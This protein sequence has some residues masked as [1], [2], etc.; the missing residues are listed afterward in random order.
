MEYGDIALDKPVINK[1][2]MAILLTT[3]ERIIL[4]RQ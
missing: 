2:P 1:N 4:A 3:G